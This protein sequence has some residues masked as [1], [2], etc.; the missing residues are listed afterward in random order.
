MQAKGFMIVIL[1]LC[2]FFHSCAFADDTGINLISGPDPTQNPVN[3]DDFRVGDTVNLDGIGEVTLTDALIWGRIP[4][5]S[6]R[7]YYNS[8]LHEW[9]WTDFY[10]EGEEA[11]YFRIQIDILNTQKEPVDYI[12]LIHNPICTFDEEYEFGGW[13]RQHTK[14][15]G[16]GDSLDVLSDS[17]AGISINTMYRGQYSIVFTLP[18]DVVKYMVSDTDPRPTRFEF[19]IGDSKITYWYN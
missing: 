7:T 12:K 8:I 3:M 1:M 13:V 14:I 18:R 5:Y 4:K 17:P 19:S 15:Q 6:E 16:E 10:Y 11:M 2:V 9:Y